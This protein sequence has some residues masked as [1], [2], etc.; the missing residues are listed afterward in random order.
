MSGDSYAAADVEELRRTAL[1]NS[2]VA[3]AAEIAEDNPLAM[4]LVDLNAAPSAPEVLPDGEEWEE[5]RSVI[6][7]V[8]RD[9]IGELDEPGQGAVTV[10]STEVEQ[11]G[12]IERRTVTIDG[13]AIGPIPTEILV[14]VN[15][16]QPR[17]AIVACHPTN[18]DGKRAVTE[19]VGERRT[20]YALE[21]ALRGYVVITPD[22]LTAGERVADGQEPFNTAG[23]YEQFPNSTLIARNHVDMLSALNVLEAMPEVDSGRIGA[24]GHSLG[25]YTATFLAGLDSRVRAVVNSCGFSPFRHD[26]KPTRWG[27]RGWYTH[28]PRVNSDL[29]RGRVPFEF[30]Q[31]SALMAPVP[32]FNYLGQL[33]AIFPHWRAVAEALG[34]MG[35]LYSTLGH[36]EDFVT[37]MGWGPHG[38]PP[39]IRSLAYDFLDQRLAGPG[40]VG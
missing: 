6:L 11:E 38:F 1:P 15:V 27:I 18:V 8:W 33:D 12:Q 4:P 24:I 5:R 28:L 32:I 2:L 16:E 21:L 14:P 35:K 31:V 25:G 20:P 26:P 34:E 30:S 22:M 19:A 39:P 37:L 10:R 23:F 7:R 9:Y 29:A 36:E 40:A 13:G 17:P 3:M